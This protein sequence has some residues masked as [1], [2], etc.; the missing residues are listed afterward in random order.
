MSQWDIF[1]TQNTECRGVQRASKLIP[2]RRQKSLVGLDGERN[3]PDDTNMIEVNELRIQK[4]PSELVIALKENLQL[5]KGSL[6]RAENGNTEEIRTISNL[7]RLLICDDS[8]KTGG[9]LIWLVKQCNFQGGIRVGKTE[10]SVDEFRNKVVFS[11]HEGSDKNPPKLELKICDII[12]NTAEQD[13]G[14]HVDLGRGRAHWSLMV[15]L[16]MGKSE[17]TNPQLGLFLSYGAQVLDL[18][19]RFLRER[20]NINLK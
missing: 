5:L 16:E 9:L 18:G 7:L 11:E 13:G 19:E 2:K 17:K 20:F 6:M 8:N 15:V 10:I 12:K 4:D 3:E 14:S 1:T